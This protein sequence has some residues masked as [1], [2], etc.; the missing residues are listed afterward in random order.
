MV[1]QIEGGHGLSHA[2][3]TSQRQSRGHAWRV[4]RGKGYGTSKMGTGEISMVLQEG[5]ERVDE[6]LMSVAPAAEV[7]QV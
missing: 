2:A 5:S 7:T 6:P 3:C 1:V 4:V